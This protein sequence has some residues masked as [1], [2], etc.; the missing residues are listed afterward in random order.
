MQSLVGVVFNRRCTY[1]AAPVQVMDKHPMKWNLYWLLVACVDQFVNVSGKGVQTF[2]DK[3]E[4]STGSARS[5]QK[6]Y[7]LSFDTM[8]SKK[9]KSDDRKVIRNT[10][11]HVNVCR[12]IWGGHSWDVHTCRY[13]LFNLIRQCFSFKLWLSLV[14]HNAVDDILRMIWW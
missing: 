5:S 8:S 6:V 13:L 2:E 7:G 1:Y 3:E 12:C 4:K 11:T 10:R 14:F 9:S